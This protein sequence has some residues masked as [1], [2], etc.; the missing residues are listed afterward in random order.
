M[1]TIPPYRA[2][3]PVE[4]PRDPPLDRFQAL[5]ILERDFGFFDTAA[6]GGSADGNVSRH[7]LESIRDREPDSDRGRAAGWLLDHPEALHAVDIAAQGGSADG[8]ISREDVRAAAGD[9]PAARAQV[10]TT[11][12]D[13]FAVF[14]T[15]AKGGNPDGKVSRDDL[16][17]VRDGAQFTEAQ[18]QAAVFL[19]E[20]GGYPDRLDNA[21]RSEEGGSPDG[22]ISREDVDTAYA[23]PLPASQQPLLESRQVEGSDQPTI[24]H[25]QADPPPG[26]D[27][28]NDSNRAGTVSVYVDGRYYADATILNENGGN[29]DLN[30]G[31]LGPGAHT[32]QVRDSTAGAAAGSGARVSNVQ[33]S[34]P[35]TPTGDAALAARYAPVVHLRNDG[36]VG[37]N[38]PLLSGARV[39]HNSDG[40][41][42]I[43]YSVVYSNEDAGYGAD[44]SSLADNYGRTTD[45]EHAYQI[46]LDANGT[47]IRFTSKSL[48]SADGADAVAAL[49]AEH[50]R[51]GRPEL[52]IGDGHNRYVWTSSDPARG[53][54]RVFSGA[55][56]V[57][58]QGAGGDDRISSVDIMNTQPW[59]WQV[60]SREIAR[61]GKAGDAMPQQRLY[62]SL[63]AGSFSDVGSV[64]VTLQDGSQKTVH[65]GDLPD[66]DD[67]SVS[68]VL[69][70]QAT[71]Q[72]IDP[73]QVVSVQVDASPGHSVRVD[74]QRLGPN[75]L[76]VHLPVTR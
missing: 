64:R 26:A 12:N 30:L 27:W 28:G 57:I 43:D 32:V 70:D 17:A 73:G 37:N 24:V 49:L 44:P 1:S 13:D 5:S 69:R 25:L 42:T 72:L 15:A 33:I 4:P 68:I 75:D 39:T 23:A 3:V 48:G 21:A 10:L 20:H 74:A 40:T 16:E 61:E 6:H 50:G 63:D 55:P 36:Q 51:D 66:N 38:T 62:L 58:E 34:E 65:V 31:V 7:D 76:P 14:D 59:I 29:V 71:G 19:L 9:T 22:A 35:V 60:S 56:V 46:T 2:P 8:T 18:R 11:L 45:D 67:G 41:T 53:S 54:D 47:P 52:T